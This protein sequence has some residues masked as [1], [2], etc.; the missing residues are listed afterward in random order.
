MSIIKEFISIY[1]Y[2]IYSQVRQIFDS[3][4]AEEDFGEITIKYNSAINKSSESEGVIFS[5][6]KISN[7]GEVVQVLS[8]FSFFKEIMYK[9]GFLFFGRDSMN[10]ADIG[11]DSISGKV[12]LFDPIE[13]VY[14]NIAAN[15]A[16]FLNY[17]RLF[18]EYT[19][20]PIEIRKENNTR[21][22]FREKIVTAVGGDEFANYY[23]F[24]FPKDDELKTPRILEFPFEV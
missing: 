19:I 18:L 5:M 6:L 11:F 21:V 13:R 7:I 14:A 4:K 17:L 3:L 20:M 9:N 12:I 2:A 15:E 23:S 10:N 22:V 16:C 1:Q 24:I 8:H